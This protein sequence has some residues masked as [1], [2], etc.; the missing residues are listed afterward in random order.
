MFQLNPELSPIC[1]ASCYSSKN[2]MLQL[3]FDSHCAIVKAS[4]FSTV[5]DSAF[6]KIC[7][8]RSEAFER[9]NLLS[10]IFKC[11]NHAVFIILLDFT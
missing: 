5:N 9:G 7:N 4:H 1:T 6:L 11:L 10:S 3:G 8:R 2:N